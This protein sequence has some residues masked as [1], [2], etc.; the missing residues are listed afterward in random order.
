MERCPCCKARLAGADVCPRCQADL[1]SV[2]SSEQ[3]ARHWLAHA[4]RFWFEHEPELAMLALVKS[5]R[6]EKTLT[7][8]AFCDFISQRQEQ[9]VLALL[10]QRQLAEAKQLLK[11]L[12]E[13]QP[14][15]ELLKQLQGFSGSLLA[16]YIALTG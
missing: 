7:A 5:L 11:L 4:V 10:A 15:N 8:L 6:L 1:G 2:I 16:E 12:R 13:L 3:T 14:D 9:E